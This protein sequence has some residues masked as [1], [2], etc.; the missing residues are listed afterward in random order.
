MSNVQVFDQELLVRG[1]ASEHH[2]Q[3]FVHADLRQTESEE[4]TNLH[5]RSPGSTQSNGVFF[6]N[7]FHYGFCKPIIS[8]VPY[9]L[10]NPLK[11][12]NLFLSRL[13]PSSGWI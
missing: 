6:Y 8:I 1:R 9:A 12:L 4:N 7:Y 11:T 5:G 3:L 13:V 2:L 10:F